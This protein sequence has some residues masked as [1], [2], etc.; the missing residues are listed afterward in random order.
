MAGLTLADLGRMPYPR[1]YTTLADLDAFRAAAL[2][3]R[4]GVEPQGGRTEG[5]V[6]R[7]LSNPGVMHSLSDLMRR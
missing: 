2:R 7:F 1:E 6:T 3:Q 5:A 4:Q